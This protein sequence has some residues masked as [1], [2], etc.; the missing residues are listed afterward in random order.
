MIYED[1]F[2]RV[3]SNSVLIFKIYF[4]FA[5]LFKDIYNSSLRSQEVTLE[6]N[7]LIGKTKRISKSYFSGD[8]CVL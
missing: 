1:S 4:A 2:L 3:Y 6:V 8:T 7:N 5:H